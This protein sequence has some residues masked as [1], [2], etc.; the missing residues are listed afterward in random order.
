MSMMI[1]MKT[2]MRTNFLG[3]IAGAIVT[4]KAPV[5]YQVSIEGGFN[6]L[7]GDVVSEIAPFSGMPVTLT[8]NGTDYDLQIATY[9]LTG[10]R[11]GNRGATAV[12]RASASPSTYDFTTTSQTF[13]LTAGYHLY[14]ISGRQ[15]R[16]N[17]W[18]ARSD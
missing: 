15:L 6:V 3:W 4:L 14:H 16:H 8:F 5:N 2:R 17:V 9:T 11:S 12:L 18:L 10:R 1:M 13:A 7:T